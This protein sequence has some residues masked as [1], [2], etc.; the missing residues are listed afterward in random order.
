MPFNPPAVDNAEARHPVESGFHPTRTRSFLRPE[1]RVE[2]N[3]NACTEEVS[4][5]HVERL[6]V[7]EPN[8]IRESRRRLKNS[9]DNR[10]SHPVPRVFLA[11]INQLPRTSR[12]AHLL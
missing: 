1:R 12:P 5:C 9:P 2:P 3:I 4:R 6:Q 8:V 7:H 10:P 11:C